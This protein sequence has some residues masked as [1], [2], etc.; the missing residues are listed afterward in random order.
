MKEPNLTFAE[1]FLVASC[2]LHNVQTTLRNAIKDVL[3][4]GGRKGS[5]NKYLENAM[6]LLHGTY[7]LG[8]YIP[9]EF[10]R[11]CWEKAKTEIGINNKDIRK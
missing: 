3:G 10:L 6:Q 9:H 2:S 5:T 11:S 4:E 8:N 1:D 7:N